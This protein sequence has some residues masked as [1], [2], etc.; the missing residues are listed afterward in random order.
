[1]Q[2]R[3]AA[4]YGAFFLVL[5]LGSYGMIAAASPPSISVSNPDYRVANDSQFSAGGV[6]YHAEVSGGSATLGWTVS[7]MAYSV[8]WEDGAT[9]SFQGTN[10]TVAIPDAADP[11]TVELTEARPLPDDAETTEVNGTEYVV[12]EGEN[13]T[14]ELVPIDRY[15]NETYGPAE[16]RTLQEGESYDY[17]G[18][19]STLET[20][21][22]ESATLT[23][24]AP[25][26]MSERLS[27]GD[28]IEL[29]GEPHVAHFANPSLLLLDSDLEAYE[30]QVAAIDTYDERINGLWGVSIL[31]GLTVFTLIGLSYLPSRY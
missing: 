31:S 13:D 22:N 30:E 23:W 26:T 27:E 12:V 21:E 6:T 29:G 15:L 9:V 2:R 24:T 7:D 4:V 25:G 11:Q 14:R 18:N 16:V 10:Y 8:D 20:V 28:T 17:Q 1:M 3:A 5:A 19:Q